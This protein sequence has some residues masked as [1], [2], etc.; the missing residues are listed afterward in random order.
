[1][2]I[3]LGLKNGIVM[4]YKTNIQARFKPTISCSWGD[5]TEPGQ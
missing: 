4:S 1:M 3:K 5:A 2:Q